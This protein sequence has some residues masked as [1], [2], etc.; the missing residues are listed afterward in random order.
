VLHPERYRPQGS[1]EAT[2]TAVESSE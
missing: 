1:G 2:S